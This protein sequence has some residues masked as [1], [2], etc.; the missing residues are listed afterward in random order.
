MPEENINN[1]DGKEDENDV[2]SVVSSIVEENPDSR[3]CGDTY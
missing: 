3:V 1:E 2:P